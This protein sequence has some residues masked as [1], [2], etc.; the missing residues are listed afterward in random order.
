MANQIHSQ[1]LTE[2]EA[3][4]ESSMNGYLSDLCMHNRT[5]RAWPEAYIRQIIE[6]RFNLR[7]SGLQIERTSSLLTTP[8][9]IRIIK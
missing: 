6:D 2:A 9:K 8:P 3:A 1:R 5:E 7:R 4:L